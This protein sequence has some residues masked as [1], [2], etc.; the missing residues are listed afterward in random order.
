MN[1][2]ITLRNLYRTAKISGESIIPDSNYL[3]L[4]LFMVWT[5]ADYHR[6]VL[7]ARR[8]RAAKLCAPQAT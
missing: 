5:G 3:S 1:V 8:R 2:F 7:S 4:F 6:H